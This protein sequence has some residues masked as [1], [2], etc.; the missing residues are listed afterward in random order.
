MAKRKAATTITRFFKRVK[1]N[2]ARKARRARARRANR[3]RFGKGP[4]SIERPI[5][6]TH[7]APRVTTKHLNKLSFQLTSPNPGFTQAGPVRILPLRL[8][9]AD[10]VI[11]QQ[12]FPE[13]FTTMSSLYTRY[14][15]NGVKIFLSVSGLTNTEDEKFWLCVYA[16]SHT[17]GPMDPYNSSVVGARQSRDAMLQHPGIRKKMITDSGT[18]GNPR[19]AVM[20]AGY[21][22]ISAIEEKRRTDIDDA[23]VSGTVN[24]SGSG[25]TDPALMPSIWIRWVSPRFEGSAQSRTYD[26]NVT[27]LFDVEWFDRR[28][29]L[30]TNQGEVDPA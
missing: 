30:E 9:D 1:R 22:S 17:D 20:N 7:I 23:Q 18:T 24:P 26:I 8:R 16:T 28:E 25:V 3:R 2:G 29:Q 5:R 15:V 11:K 21:F 10:F 13:N 4:R 19:S 12:T 6:F 14:R 27:L